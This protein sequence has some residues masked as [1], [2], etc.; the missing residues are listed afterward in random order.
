MKHKIMRAFWLVA[1]LFTAITC[2]AQ[3][4]QKLFSFA[5][6][7]DVQYADVE[8]SGERTYRESLGRLNRCVENLNSY[9]LEF[10]VHLGD[11]VERDFISYEKALEAFGKSKH[12]IY[13]VIGNHD[14]AVEDEFKPKVNK[15]LGLNRGGYGY[16]DT[17]DWRFLLLN[18]MGNSLLGS[19]E[20]TVEMDIA[21]K[22]WK[23]LEE[24]GAINAYNWNGGI[25]EKQLKWMERKMQ[26]AAKKGKRVVLFCHLPLYPVNE[27]ILW[28]QEEV[29]E[30]VFRY[31][32][33]FA[34]INGH[35][36]AGNY[37]TERGRHFLTVKGM[38]E[39]KMDPSYYVVDVYQDIM[40]LQGFGGEE[41]LEWDIK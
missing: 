8:T 15:L 36:H 41:D 28:N 24:E 17:G 29:A 6:I 22:K 31:D 10:I 4:G 32:N 23:E 20:G 14:L 18:G 9:D 2:Y 5:L 25:D 35:H 3:T 30:T 19:K 38:V 12:K 11:L 27:L 21:V 40:I 33:F 37:T 1:V 7:A 13:Y 34:F 16:F 39:N 26:D